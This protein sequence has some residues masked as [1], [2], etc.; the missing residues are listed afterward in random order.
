MDTFLETYNL[1]NLNQE[2]AENLNILIITNEIDTILKKLP[3][4]KSLGP[5][6]FTGKLC[7]SFKEELTPTV[8]KLFQKV[9]EEGR[10]PS[11]FLPGQYYPNSKTR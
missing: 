6:G 11:F 7:Q 8:L 9:Q 2:E 1:P 4:N 3:I 5:D 10:L